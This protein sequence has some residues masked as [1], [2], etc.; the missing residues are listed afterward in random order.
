MIDKKLNKWIEIKDFNLNIGDEVLVY[1]ESYKYGHLINHCYYEGI[2]EEGD[3]IFMN[4]GTYL[5]ILGTTHYKVPD[6][7]EID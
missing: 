2:D 6:F 3:Y 7:P 5:R 4:K 1:R